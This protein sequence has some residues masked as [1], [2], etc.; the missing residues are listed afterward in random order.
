MPIFSPIRRP[1]DVIGRRVDSS[2]DTGQAA[3]VGRVTVGRPLQCHIDAGTIL[4]NQELVFRRMEFPQSAGEVRISSQEGHD[5]SSDAR[6]GR[7]TREI[8][9]KWRR[10]ESRSLIRP[11]VFSQNPIDTCMVGFRLFDEVRPT[12]CVQLD[13]ANIFTI[14]KTSWL[15]SRARA[16]NNPLTSATRRLPLP[17]HRRVSQATVRAA[18]C[19]KTSPCS[20]TTRIRSISV[21][22]SIL[23]YREPRKWC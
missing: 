5:F 1:R 19:R 14:R 18:V 20:R 16:E 8:A 6:E 9:G 4:E 22:A 13:L 17:A 7:V 23:P 3:L 21:R 12:P 10:D 11:P 15:E 2:P